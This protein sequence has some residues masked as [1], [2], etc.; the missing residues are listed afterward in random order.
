[1]RPLIL[2][3]PTR[4]A[5]DTVRKYAIENPLCLEDMF[6]IDKGELPAAGDNPLRVCHIEAGFRV[7]YTIEEQPGAT[8]R[9]ISV[10][11]DRKDKLPSIEH[12]SAIMIAF[13]MSKLLP[14]ED[15]IQI[16]KW[17]EGESAVS[18]IQIIYE[19]EAGRA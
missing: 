16:E 4:M 6:K 12:V 11:I 13:G 17:G 18:V 15:V 14:G 3:N 9:H 19:R 7:V 8:V 10:S 1:M 2:N 5:I